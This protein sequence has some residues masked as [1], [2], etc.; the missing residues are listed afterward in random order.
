MLY[1]FAPK[2]LS[3]KS[4]YSSDC[5]WN[6]ERMIV[7]MNIIICQKIN[8]RSASITKEEERKKVFHQSAWSV[9]VF[10]T[11]EFLSLV[12]DKTAELKSEWKENRNRPAVMICFNSFEHS[13]QARLLAAE[14]YLALM[15]RFCLPKHFYWRATH[16]LSAKYPS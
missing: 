10:S 13:F 5:V 7:G 1:I 11:S 6:R 16:S 2:F 14:Q 8:S 12:K 9:L 3:V 4:F 15:F